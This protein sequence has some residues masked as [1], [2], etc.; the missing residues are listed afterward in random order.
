MSSSRLVEL[1]EFAH[2]VPDDDA[3]IPERVQEAA[4]EALLVA[5]DRFRKQ[6]QQI[7]I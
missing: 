2:L 7:D 3:E 4:K 1:G 5:A 6:Y